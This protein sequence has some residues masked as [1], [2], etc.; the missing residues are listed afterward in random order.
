[1]NCQIGLV[2]GMIVGF[3]ICFLARIYIDY[4]NE[5]KI[6]SFQ[7]KKGTYLEFLKLFKKYNLN[8]D[9]AISYDWFENEKN[10]SLVNGYIIK[11]NNVGLLLNFIDF[12]KSKIFIK[13]LGKD[14]LRKKEIKDGE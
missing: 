13:K 3:S 1:M 14:Y 5:T 11:F 4:R 2:I 9:D 10:N 8:I 12:Y 7:Y 6:H